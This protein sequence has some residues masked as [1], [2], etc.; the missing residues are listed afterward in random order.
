MEPLFIIGLLRNPPPHTHAEEHGS[1]AICGRTMFFRNVFLAG[2]HNH[3]FRKNVVLPQFAE[4]HS[5]SA[6]CGR[7][8]FFRK[9]IVMLFRKINVMFFRI[10][11]N[12]SVLPQNIPCVWKWT[13]STRLWLCVSLINAHGNLITCRG[14]IHLHKSL[15]IVLRKN[16]ILPQFAEEVCSSAK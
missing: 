2:R 3:F 8:V 1:S 5:C 14:C 10:L 11:R 15:T 16:Y 13:V 6:E 9:I 7:S 4:E 12:N